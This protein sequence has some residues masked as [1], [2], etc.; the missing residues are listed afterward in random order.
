MNG[1]IFVHK[2]SLTDCRRLSLV[3][4]FPLVVKWII[5]QKIE[6]KIKNKK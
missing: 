2:K 6:E 4:I 5:S 3:V 1:V